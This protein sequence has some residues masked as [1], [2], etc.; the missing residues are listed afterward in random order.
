MYFTC[1]ILVQYADPLPINGLFAFQLV[2]EVIGPFIIE[3][4]GFKIGNMLFAGEVT[5]KFFVRSIKIFIETKLVSRREDLPVYE[6]GIRR[7]PFYINGTQ[8]RYADT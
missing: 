1:S 3:S 7:Y 2:P 6:I 5:E 8:P 4:N